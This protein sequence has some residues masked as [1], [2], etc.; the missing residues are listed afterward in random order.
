[1]HP[2][3]I[4]AGVNHGIANHLLKEGGHCG[5]RGPYFRDRVP[6]RTFDSLGPYSWFRIHIFSVWGKFRGKMLIRSACMALIC[7]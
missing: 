1:M 6:I 2:G 3:W 4:C 5:K 7:L